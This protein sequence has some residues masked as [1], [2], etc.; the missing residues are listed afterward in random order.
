[1]FEKE[2]LDVL[3]GDL[4]LASMGTVLCYQNVF[5]YSILHC[6]SDVVDSS[7]LLIGSLMVDSLC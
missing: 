3:V 1:M 7:R 4:L 2:N 6:Q 5:A